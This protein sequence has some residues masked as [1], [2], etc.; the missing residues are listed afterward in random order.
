SRPD[1]TPI[2]GGVG[3]LYHQGLRGE[4][5]AAE[6]H[7]K[8][9]GSFSFPWPEGVT[10]GLTVRTDR[11]TGKQVSARITGSSGTAWVRLSV[12]GEYVG[13][14]RFA[15]LEAAI[16]PKLDDT[17]L[18]NVA[19]EGRVAEM[20]ALGELA[21]VPTPGVA[22]VVLAHKLEAQ[23]KVDAAVFFALLDQRA[24]PAVTAALDT[25]GEPPAL[26]AVQVEHVLDTLLRLRGDNVQAALESAVAANAIAGV[27]IEA[28]TRQLH[29][30]RIERIAT[31]P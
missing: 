9:D 24:A 13:P 19:A 27:D 31:R 3:R 18:R 14:T 29:A 15:M 23:T 20:K 10:S 28:A 26:D 7:S 5:V 4:K 2:D 8:S 21:G 1:G 6:T 12:G 16:T 11:G 30:L 17:P 22:R 25:D